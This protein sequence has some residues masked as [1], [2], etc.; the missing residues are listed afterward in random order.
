MQ[1]PPRPQRHAAGIAATVVAV[2]VVIAVVAV[3]AAVVVTGEGGAH[4]YGLG[5]CGSAIR[6][7]LTDFGPHTH[8]GRR[9]CLCGWRHP[10]LNVEELYAGGS[11]SLAALPNHLR[12]SISVAVRTPAALGWRRRSSRIVSYTVG[13]VNFP[14][15]EIEPEEH[16]WHDTNSDLRPIAG[17]RTP[18]S[19]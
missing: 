15:P 17:R 18:G 3:V 6:F 14:F 19:R 10:A 7:D 13:M 12:P 16:D 9:D 11:G 5:R 8:S 4:V 1:S 2:V